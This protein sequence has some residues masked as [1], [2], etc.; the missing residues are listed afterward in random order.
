M[1]TTLLHI[2]D[3]DIRKELKIHEIQ[4]KINTDNAG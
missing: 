1:V 3:A 4:N 2:K